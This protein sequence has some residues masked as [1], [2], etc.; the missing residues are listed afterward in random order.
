MTR[1]D[2]IIEAVAAAGL[3][4]ALYA[5]ATQARL[6][7][8]EGAACG[9]VLLGPRSR[10]LGVPN[11]LVGAVFYAGVMAAFALGRGQAGQWARGA[12]AVAGLAAAGVSVYLLWSLMRRDGTCPICLAGNA[13][14]LVLAGLLAAAV[15]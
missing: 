8:R 6:R 12:A 7:R 1:L 15:V 5:L 4:N 2:W 13:I 10:L 9:S 3:L 14:N 11:T